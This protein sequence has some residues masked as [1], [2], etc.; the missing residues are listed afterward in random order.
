MDRTYKNRS[1]GFRTGL[2]RSKIFPYIIT[3]SL[4]YLIDL[5]AIVI[6][7]PLPVP[8]PPPYLV[9][10]KIS[11]APGAT[12]QVQNCSSPGAADYNDVVLHCFRSNQN[13]Q[14]ALGVIQPDSSIQPKTMRLTILSPSLYETNGDLQRLIPNHVILS[15]YSLDPRAR[16][17]LNFSTAIF[18]SLIIIAYIIVRTRCLSKLKRSEAFTSDI[19]RGAR[20]LVP[21]SL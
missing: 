14:A 16:R 13:I 6:C 9:T 21:T 17:A 10:R 4:F 20:A 8:P 5:G 12:E 1:R 19:H 15:R 11:D 3:G 18:A 2:C 7:T